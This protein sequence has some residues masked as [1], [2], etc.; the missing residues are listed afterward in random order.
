MDHS[1]YGYL[2]RRSTEELE[3]ILQFCLQDKNYS[4]VIQDVLDVLEKR[5]LPGVFPPHIMQIRQHLA[6]KAEKK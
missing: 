1:V 3:G 5:Y 4:H 2:N 6:E